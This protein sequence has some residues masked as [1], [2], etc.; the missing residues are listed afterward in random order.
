[1]SRMPFWNPTLQLSS[2][3]ADPHR[4]CFL[5]PQHSKGT[6]ATCLSPCTLQVGL[7]QSVNWSFPT[8]T[9]VP[10]MS[11]AG[12]S[13]RGPGGANRVRAAGGVGLCQRVVTGGPCWRQR[14][15]QPEDN[16]ESGPGPSLIIPP[17]RTLFPFSKGVLRL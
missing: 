16:P 1:M 2:P 5:W 8:Q 6:W 12:Q 11:E 14:R 7:Q 10:R 13:L 4:V 9:E 3:C 17:K 15:G